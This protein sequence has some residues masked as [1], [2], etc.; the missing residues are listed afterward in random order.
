MFTLS[1]SLSCES[2]VVIYNMTNKK[3]KIYIVILS[4][5]FLFSEAALGVL[6]PGL[7]FLKDCFQGGVYLELCYEVTVTN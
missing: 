5:Q 1:Q 2:M 6:V 7:P 4:F 3:V